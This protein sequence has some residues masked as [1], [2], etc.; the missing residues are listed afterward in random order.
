MLNQKA[1]KVFIFFWLYAFFS[2]D[3]S[4]L[5]VILH[6]SLACTAVL[7]AVNCSELHSEKNTNFKTDKTLK[8]FSLLF[9][10]KCIYV[11]FYFLDQH[12]LFLIH[13][14]V[15]NFR[16]SYCFWV[17]LPQDGNAWFQTPSAEQ[18]ISCVPVNDEPASQSSVA[19]VSRP[20][21]LRLKLPLVG[22]ISSS[23]FA[24]IYNYYVQTIIRQLQKKRNAVL[25]ATILEHISREKIQK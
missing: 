17:Y 8:F 13:F 14:R 21:E 9:S 25:I 19:V 6:R 12:I 3:N 20:L 15:T 23:H 11:I 2:F 22:E 16:V 1:E 7:F 10:F 5:H 4:L 24:T 18:T